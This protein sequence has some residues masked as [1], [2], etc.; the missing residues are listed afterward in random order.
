MKQHQ[1]EERLRLANVLKHLGRG[2]LMDAP[3]AVA[4]ISAAAAIVIP[5][6]GF[7]LTKKK[8]RE[9]EWQK[10]KFEH[11]KELVLSFSGVVEADSTPEGKVRFARACNTLLLVASKDALDA[12]YD[13]Q[14]EIRAPNPARSKAT[15]DALLSRLV[16]HIRADL[17]IPQNPEESAFN[18]RL[19]SAGAAPERP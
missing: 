7:Y 1:A 11:Y 18:A 13:F 6:I 8:E 15:D 16:W 2:V 19:W 14:N 10:S 3:I 17:R 9:A 12:L 5:A 4:V